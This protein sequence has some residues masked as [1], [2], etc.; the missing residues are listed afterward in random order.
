MGRSKKYVLAC[1]IYIP[2]NNLVMAHKMEANV[3]SQIPAK[4]TELNVNYLLSIEKPL[5]QTVAAHICNFHSLHI[6]HHIAS[7]AL[8]II[9][10]RICNR[11]SKHFYVS[12]IY[13]VVT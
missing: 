7:A 3:K 4:L 10:D 12:A 11:L 13:A 2:W 8:H 9:Y 6:N 5:A 1:N